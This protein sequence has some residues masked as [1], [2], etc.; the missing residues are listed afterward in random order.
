MIITVFFKNPQLCFFQHCGETCRHGS[1]PAECSVLV[2]PGDEPWSGAGRRWLTSA[3]F[4]NIPW[5][6]RK[7]VQLHRGFSSW[8]N[9]KGWNVKRTDLWC[10]G[11]G[12][13]PAP[14]WTNSNRSMGGSKALHVG[15]EAAAPVAC[16]GCFCPF[17]LWP[18]QVF[19]S[20]FISHRQL[21]GSMS[22]SR[23]DSPSQAACVDAFQASLVSWRE[24]VESSPPAA[25]QK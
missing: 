10:G 14:N 4:N 23:G 2:G 9:K 17:L 12:G 5:N 18:L 7:H 11:G 20:R 13:E 19:S 3:A 16:S 15:D 24:T 6:L 1:G 21:H 22:C 8:M 25:V